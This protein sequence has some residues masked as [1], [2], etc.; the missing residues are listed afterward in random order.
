MSYGGLNQETNDE[1]C[2][3][4]MRGGG[5]IN[6]CSFQIMWMDEHDWNI[7]DFSI[8]IPY[9]M[10][11]ISFFY[12]WLSEWDETKPITTKWAYH[13]WWFK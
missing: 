2:Q 6:I 9:T 12:P 7:L 13:A 8:L 1:Q 5:W 11:L 3:S 4:L 10:G